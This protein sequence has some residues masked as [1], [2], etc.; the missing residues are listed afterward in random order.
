MAAFTGHLLLDEGEYD[1]SLILKY[2][3]PYRSLQVTKF[4]LFLQAYLFHFLENVAFLKVFSVNVP[5][6]NTLKL[7]FL[8][9]M[10]LITT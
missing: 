1:E 5:E 7:V 6:I 4:R 2:R 3:V 8:E 9:A 10:D